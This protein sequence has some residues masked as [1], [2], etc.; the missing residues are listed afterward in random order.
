MKLFNQFRKY[1]LMDKAGEGEGGGGG[2]GA[3]GEGKGE[4]DEGQGDKVTL[5]KEQYDGLMA[6][7]DK[8]EGKGK[9]GRGEGEGDDDD[10]ITKAK[11]AKEQQGKDQNNSKAL[12]SA[13]RFSMGSDQWL[14]DNKSLLPSEVE[15]IFTQAN[16]ETYDSPIEKDAAL[17][18]GIVQSFFSVQD[19]LDLLTPGLKN[20]VEDYLKLT[21]NGKQEKAQHVYESIFEPTFEMLKRLKKAESLQKGHNPGDNI[22]DGYKQRLMKLSQKHYIGE[23]KDA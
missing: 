23:S 8:L 3:G 22:Q 18:S 12:E 20:Q 10:L 5:S 15:D 7:I 11:K 13:L 16:K 17:K 4:G 19:N 21:K 2:A 1:H 9:E 14:K 6:R